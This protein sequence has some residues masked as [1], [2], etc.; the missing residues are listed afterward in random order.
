[1]PIWYIGCQGG[2]MQQISLKMVKDSIEGYEGETKVSTP[3]DSYRI[4]K[5]F[6]DTKPN[7]HLYALYLNSHNI[8][9]GL[10]LIAQGTI[11][12]ANLSPRDVL[13]PA[14][15]CAAQ[16]IILAHN[17]P[18]GVL[19]ASDADIEITNQLIAAGNLLEIPVVDHIIVGSFESGFISMRAKNLCDFEPEETLTLEISLDAS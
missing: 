16:K 17:H 1:M 12:G 4:L 6:L 11:N 8:V 15:L 5:P 19:V 18:S 7:E 2:Y 10:S 14:L 3:L 13:A 9:V